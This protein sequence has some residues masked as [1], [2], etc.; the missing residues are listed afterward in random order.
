V[1]EVAIGAV[2]EA[3]LEIED[4]KVV[5][6]HE[7]LADP[8]QDLVQDQE[9]DHQKDTVG[10]TNLVDITVEEIVEDQVQIQ[11]ILPVQIQIVKQIMMSEQYL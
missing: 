6:N 8:D 10:I 2:I 9:H 7:D 11:I 1:T 5:K 4:T 3:D